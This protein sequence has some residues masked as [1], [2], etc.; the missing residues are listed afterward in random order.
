MWL[1][2]LFWGIDKGTLLG[3]NYHFWVINDHFGGHCGQILQQKSCPPPPF[4]PGFWEHLEPQPLPNVEVSSQLSKQA[5]DLILRQK[6]FTDEK[7]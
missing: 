1:N 4:W 5:F 3:R 2:D 7:K 6:V